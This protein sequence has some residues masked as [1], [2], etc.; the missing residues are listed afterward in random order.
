MKKIEYILFVVLCLFFCAVPAVGM[1][2]QKTDATT[3]NRTLASL[4]EWKKDD[5]WNQDYFEEFGSYFEDHF[6][7]R[8]AFV[9]ADSVIQSKVFGVSNVD[10]VL[11]GKNG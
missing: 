5:K 8:N 10:T 11:V 4:P 2:I 1:S 7:F 6:A 3:E 9:M